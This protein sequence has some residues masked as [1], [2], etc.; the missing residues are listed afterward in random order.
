M[1]TPNSCSPAARVIAA[2]P[3]DGSVTPETETPIERV[4]AA[5]RRPSVGQGRQLGPGFG[6]G[7]AD[8]LDDDRARDSAPADPLLLVLAPAWRVERDVVGD[9]HRLDPVPG[10][11]GEIGAEA[12]VQH[13][14]RCSS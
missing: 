12:E 9:E 2:S 5:T 1:P 14:A 6:G 4:A 8:L 10:P 13:V 3:P 11:A 7:S